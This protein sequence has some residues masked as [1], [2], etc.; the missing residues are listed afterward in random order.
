[1]YAFSERDL[2]DRWFSFS[3]QHTIVN[4]DTFNCLVYTYAADKDDV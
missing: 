1:M 4:Y 3:R 2:S